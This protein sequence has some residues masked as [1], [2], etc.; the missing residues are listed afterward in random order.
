[1][2]I[3]IASAP[4]SYGVFEITV[5]QPG[6]PEGEELAR[7]MAESGY[8]GTELG[9]PGYFGTGAEVGRMLATHGL[10]LMGSFLPLSFSRADRFPAD[11]EAMDR[12][13]D[14]LEVAG[15]DQ[16]PVVLLSDAFVEPDRI[17]FAGDIENH[18]ETWLDEARFALLI[19]NLEKAAG[20]CRERGFAASLH[21]HAG[22]YVETP[23]EIE[24]VV[25]AIDTSKVGL[26]FDTGHSAFGGGDPLELLER[27]GDV[28]NHVHMKDVDLAGLRALRAEGGDL[29]AAWK[30]GI[31]C[32][33]GTGDAH[34]SECL[35]EL[36]RRGYDGWLVVE[37]DRVLA[38]DEPF[39][40]AVEDG[41][42]NR[43]FL[44]ERGL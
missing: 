9:P 23:R 2:S 31:F 34:V 39:S 40:V 44:A 11:Y 22:T 1:M 18:P 13:L 27:H 19:E 25:T 33:L 36:R 3:R 15:G 37:Q 17:K 35:D 7:V 28:V 16:L 24:S 42:K 29:I 38:D 43:E 8:T 41:K 21:Y 12:A 20:R 10:E 4:C 32:A 14:T 5:D 30:A 6:L 26:C